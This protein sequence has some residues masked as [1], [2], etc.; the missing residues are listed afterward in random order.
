M[1]VKPSTITIPVSST[2]FSVID[3]I[4]FVPMREETQDDGSGFR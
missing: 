1:R 2:F 3:D 4:T